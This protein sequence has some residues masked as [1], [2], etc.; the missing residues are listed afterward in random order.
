[1]NILKLFEIGNGLM[2]IQTTSNY[3]SDWEEDNTVI[4]YDAKNPFVEAIRISVITI[5]SDSK[6]EN[7]AYKR[8]MNNS[9]TM[10]YN[11]ITVNDKCYYTYDEISAK[12][13]EVLKL[14]FF[15]IGYKNHIIV[16]SITTLLEYSDNE[17]TKNVLTDIPRLIA[18]INEISLE[19]MTLFEPKQS[20]IQDIY[21]RI[22]KIEKSAIDKFHEKDNRINFIQ[23]LLDSNNCNEYDLQS[24]GLLLG[25]YFI[26]TNSNYHWI[27]VRDEFGRD[28]GLQY[29][30]LPIILFPMSLIYNRVKDDE[31]VDVLELVDDMTDKV[32]KLLADFGYS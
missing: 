1:M 22:S 9:K 7:I 27:V 20:D 19:Y 23:R 8:I 26:N 17:P 21:D 14:F 15:E 29:K 12:D 11:V 28:I 2:S 30:D 4:L 10:D 5:E 24:L 3:C 25:N 16:I 18:S 13:G 6:L 31:K 32:D